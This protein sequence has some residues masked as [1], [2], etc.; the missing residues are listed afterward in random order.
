ME[1]TCSFL[2]TGLYLYRLRR[3]CAVTEHVKIR[4]QKSARSLAVSTSKVTLGGSCQKKKKKKT[5][6][7]KQLL[8]VRYLLVL[9]NM[10]FLFRTA[11]LC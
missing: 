11:H 10:N 9:L 6:L 3:N 4:T 8:T 7:H 2:K 5:P 1:G